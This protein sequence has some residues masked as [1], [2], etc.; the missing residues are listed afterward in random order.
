MSKDSLLASWNRYRATLSA[1]Q[2]TALADEQATIMR[3]IALGVA[4]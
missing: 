2:L 3:G 4:I 1:D